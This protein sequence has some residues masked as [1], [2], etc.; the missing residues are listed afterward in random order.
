MSVF[1]TVL[2]VMALTSAALTA[3]AGVLEK[4]AKIQ[5]DPTIVE[6]A[7]KV[8]DPMGANLVRY[9]LRA[10]VRD[11]HIE[12]G[13]SPI[14][15]HFVLDEFSSESRAH[16]IIDMGSGRSVCTVDGKLVFEDAGGKELASV[17]I[18]VRG[19]VVSAQGEGN[20]AQGHAESSDLERRLLKEIEGLK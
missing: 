2:F 4:A 15:A 8:D 16:R 6:H 1:R 3:F 12:E 10:A 18:H 7:E 19:S 20:T 5:V 11:A 13:A 9:D 14:R 17:R